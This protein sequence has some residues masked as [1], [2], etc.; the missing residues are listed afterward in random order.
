MKIDIFA[1]A[2]CSIGCFLI[3]L[4]HNVFI[5][6]HNELLNESSYYDGKIDQIKQYREWNKLAKKED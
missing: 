1:I 3:N 6:R 5:T 4:D 2:I